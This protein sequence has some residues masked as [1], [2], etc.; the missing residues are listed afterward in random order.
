MIH[1]HQ[2]CLHKA[3]TFQSCSCT[4]AGGRKDYRV[5][6]KCLSIFPKVSPTLSCAPKDVHSGQLQSS[7]WP[8]RALL[9]LLDNPDYTEESSFAFFLTIFMTPFSP[10]QKSALQEAQLPRALHGVCGKGRDRRIHQLRL[11]FPNGTYGWMD[12]LM[13]H[14]LWP[15]SDSQPRKTQTKAAHG[16]KN[17]ALKLHYYV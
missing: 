16:G 6:P 14:T 2:L 1:S 4:G 17:K 12:S 15:T 7:G 10:K 13:M 8:S 5:K 9:R 3:K 11:C